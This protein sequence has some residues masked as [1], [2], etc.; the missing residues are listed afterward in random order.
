[1]RR[2]Y[3]YFAFMLLAAVAFSCK[4]SG[5][6]AG[7]AK[8]SATTEPAEE[9]FV[10]PEV[11]DVCSQMDDP[12]FKAFCYKHFDTDSDG[13]VS[14][15]EAAAVDELVIESPF[16]SEEG[17][18]RYEFDEP[19]HSLKGIEYFPNLYALVFDF[20][21]VTS[22]DVRNNT[23]LKY[24][25]CS[26]NKIGTLDV[27]KN[28]L[29]RE[30]VCYSCGLTGLDVSH[31]PELLILSCSDNEIPSINVTN[32]PKLTDLSCTTNK[33][34]TLDL[35]NNPVLERLHCGNNLLTS[36]DL[37]KNPELNL[38]FCEGNQLTSLDLSKNPKLEWVLCKRNNITSL[39]L[40]NNSKVTLADVDKET[41]LIGYNR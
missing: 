36:L 20:H 40:S 12:S 38:L 8:N 39:D 32:C 10:L 3:T 34:S 31:N 33:I 25:H 17:P 30:L 24:L 21:Q 18:S 23:Q 13:K 15:A 29:L 19:V 26:S 35:S 7:D 41:E 6:N 28:P 27:S 22:L 5:E 4:N 11:D 16:A 1:M 37:S 2:L 14:M 9:A